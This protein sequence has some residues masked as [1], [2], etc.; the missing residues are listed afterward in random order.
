MDLG[1]IP[2]ASAGEIA[3]AVR[4]RQVSA[5]E[6]TEAALER[7]TATDGSL[8][9]FRHVDTDGA[10]ATAAALD[11]ARARGDELGPLAGVPVGV[12]EQ[13][14]VAG[15]PR[16]A[17][18]LLLKGNREPSDGPAVARLRAAGA[19]IV[20]MTAMPEFG[21]LA[22]GHSPLGPATRN[23]WS[24]GHTP[25]GSS[26]GS[27][28]ALAAGQVALAL[29]TDGGGSIRIPAACCGVVGHK[30]TLGRVPHA[31]LRHG[32]APMSHLGPM[33]RS[34]ADTALLLDVI[35]AQDH[36]DPASLPPEGLSYTEIASRP[37][38][39][40]RIAWAPQL[41]QAE[42]DPEVLQ[43][44]RA[45]VEALAADGFAVTEMEPFLDDWIESWATLF[46]ASLA[47]N[48]GDRL[49]D[50]RRLSDATL[51][52]RVEHGH[53]ISATDFLAAEADRREVWAAFERVYH[54]FDVVMTPALLQPPLSVDPV[55]GVTDAP[56]SWVERW[57]Q[58]MYPFNMTGQPAVSVPAGLTAD[59]LPVAMQ[60]V[61][62]RLA[63]GVT[64]GFA[65]A[66][67]QRLGW[68]AAQPTL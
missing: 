24:A 4:E 65:A 22:F 30:P 48:V 20:G 31:P 16:E 68:D 47:L 25:G 23:P 8:R 3:G 21:H 7:I 41:G 12:K 6:V 67:E 61:G 62:P 13:V 26:S 18:S 46:D 10:R 33:A 11:A 51:I 56:D 32:F 53:R 49:E 37:P 44:C 59:G 57:F 14:A 40:G 55:T 64:L 45:A 1:D 42:A 15:L 58:H 54:D 60:V 50:M 19:V 17:G 39:S 43:P 38:E 34:V 52:A 66:V 36:A 9:A 63:D 28:A 27:A 2:F 5:R 35:A 29:G